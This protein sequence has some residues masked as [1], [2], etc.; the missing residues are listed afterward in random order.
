[1]TREEQAK[2]L[3]GKCCTWGR[4]R[5][6]H[7]GANLLGQVGKLVEEMEEV[8]YAFDEGIREPFMAELGDNYVVAI[9]YSLVFSKDHDENESVALLDSICDLLSG[10]EEGLTLPEKKFLASQSRFRGTTTYSKALTNMILGIGQ[11]Q[12]A[13]NKNKSF[14]HHGSAMYCYLMA[15]NQIADSVCIDPIEC[16]E[17]AYEKI[18]DRKGEWR[19]G[20]FIKEADL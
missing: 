8:V 10:A 9:L 17:M 7:T 2:E 14:E 11:L 20:M 18:K 5:N 19:N 16:L 1:M 6:F 15:L 4:E 3:V 13:A 12:T